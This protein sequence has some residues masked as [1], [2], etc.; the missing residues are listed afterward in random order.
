MIEYKHPLF[1]LNNDR[2]DIVCKYLFFKNLYYQE[3]NQYIK[4][5]YTKHI[6]ERTKGKEPRD[7][8]LPF[9]EQKNSIEDYLLSCNILLGNI[10]KNGYD[11]N[12]PIFYTNTR[13][14]NGAHRIACSILFDIKVPCIF[15][16]NDK[17]FKNWGVEWFVDHNFNTLDIA[18]LKKEYSRLKT[19]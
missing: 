9:L 2:L 8:N 6:L 1:F 10:S 19:I 16:S 4:F 7:P 13:I 11:F 14:I 12:F 18:Y 17:K 3:N 15:V 5:L